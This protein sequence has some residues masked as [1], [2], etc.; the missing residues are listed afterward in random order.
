MRTPI[1]V[2]AA[3]T[4]LAPRAWANYPQVCGDSYFA[5]EWLHSLAVRLDVPVV[6]AGDVFDVNRP[7]S[8]SVHTAQRV[9]NHMTAQTGRNVYYT[10]GQ[11]ELA[12]P[13]WLTLT[14]AKHIHR[15]VVNLGGVTLYGMDFTRKERLSA[16]LARVPKTVDMLVAHQVWRDHIDNAPGA[17][18]AFADVPHVRAMLTG[19]FHGHRVTQTVGASGQALAVLSPGS[20]CMQAA[21]ESADKYV[22][23]LYSDLWVESVQLPG[24]PVICHDLRTAEQ[25]EAAVESVRL[26]AESVKAAAVAKGVPEAVATPL[27]LVRYTTGITR[28]YAALRAVSGV[29]LMTK[30]LMSD[31]EPAPMGGPAVSTAGVSTGLLGCLPEIVDEDDPVFATCDRLL[32]AT[33]PDKELA[34]LIKE[35]LNGQSDGAAQADGLA[36]RATAVAGATVA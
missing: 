7:D 14:A 16:E 5:F 15:S 4:H 22:Y 12:D 2:L 34:D 31:D 29:H 19:D 26:T 1:A 3:D 25:L 30:L 18:A 35:R 36:G 20:T 6:L 8:L 32:R 28:A 9:I 10:Q 17:E 13:P 11:H 21:D 27:W 24:R 23:V 33:D